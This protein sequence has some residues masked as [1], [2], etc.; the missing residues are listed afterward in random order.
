MA[1]ASSSRYTRYLSSFNE[2]L[3]QQQQDLE[4]LIHGAASYANDPAKLRALVDK[5]IRHFEEYREIRLQLSQ[6]DAPAFLCPVW[7]TTLEN[8]L[9]WIGG[10]RPSMA[11]RLVYS[12]VGTELDARFEQYLKGER[13]GTL[14]EISS[15]QM[16]QINSLHMKI[17]RE[18]DKISSRMASLQEDVV[19]EP[20]AT[21]A[22]ELSHVGEPSEKADKALAGHV[23][24]LGVMLSEADKLRVSSFKELTEILTP[25][26]AVDMLIC[27]KKLHL[28]LRKWGKRWDLEKGN[29]SSDDGHASSYP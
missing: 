9:L 6:Q 15:A 27:T 16:E 13:K 8:S 2:W 24:S 18:E 17:L 19:D 28:S 29:C 26:Q 14:S 3:T 5:N 4:E 22:K 1:A 20:L 11:I 23:T 25:L 21:I 10:C 12:L 7:C